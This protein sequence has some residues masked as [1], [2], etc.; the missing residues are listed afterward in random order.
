VEAQIEITKDVEHDLR[1]LKVK[2]W[3]REAN[4][5]EEWAS[6]VKEVKVL[7]GQSS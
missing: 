3:R 1:G 2:S 7:R 5:R 4:N 6:V